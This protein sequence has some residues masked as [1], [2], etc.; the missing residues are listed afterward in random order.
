MNYNDSSIISVSSFDVSKAFDVMRIE[1]IL[2]LLKKNYDH[3]ILPGLIINL[4]YINHLMKIVHLLQGCGFSSI[5]CQYYVSF[6]I[7]IAFRD[8]LLL[9]MIYI[10][11]ITLVYSGKLMSNEYLENSILKVDN[12]IRIHTITH[13]NI[14]IKTKIP[15]TKFLIGLDCCNTIYRFRYYGRSK[16]SNYIRYYKTSYF[17]CLDND[18]L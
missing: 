9:P 3:P 5:L 17:Y 4:L 7:E 2:L 13:S 10:D 1:T 11:N 6:I 12:A 16:D 15:Y 18:S 8:R 14:S